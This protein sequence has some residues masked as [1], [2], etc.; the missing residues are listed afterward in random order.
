MDALLRACTFQITDPLDSK[1]D[2]AWVEGLSNGEI[3]EMQHAEF[4]ISKVIKWLQN[5]CRPTWSEIK[6]K[7]K[8]ED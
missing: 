3:I 6:E 1:I 4:N 5:G 7:K 2:E 8:T